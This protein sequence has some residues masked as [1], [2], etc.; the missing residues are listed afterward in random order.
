M[1]KAQYQLYCCGSRGS[2]PVEGKRFNEFG[3]FTS[4][5]VLKKEDYARIIDC[6]TGLYEANSIV[7]NCTKIDVVLTHIHY[8]HLMGMLDW[9]SIPGKAELTFYGN[10]D[11]WFGDKTF[12]E[13]FRNPFWPVQPKYELRQSPAAGELLQLRKDLS[14][15]FYSAPHPDGAKMLVIRHDDATEHRMAVMFDC[16][17]S[18]A[19]PYD[20]LNKSDYII[21]DGMYDDMEYPSHRGY[22]HSTWQEGCRL[23][24]RVNCSRLI[25]TH[26]FPAR[27]DDQLRRME[28]LARDMYPETDFARSGQNWE[29][30]YDAENEGSQ[31]KTNKEKKSFRE[32]VNEKLTELVLN[33]EQRARLLSIGCYMILGVVSVFMT[34][35]NVAT[36]KHLLMVSTLAFAIA[37]LLDVLFVT[38]FDLNY[39]SVQTVFQIEAL[40]LFAFFI[41]SGT[42][43]GFSAIWS[44]LLP[45]GGML[46]FGKRRTTILSISMLCI[47]VFFFYTVPGRNLLQYQYTESFMLRFPMAFVAF[48]LTAYFLETIRERTVNEL[49]RLK[50]NQADII[51]VQT[52]ELRE[53]NFDMIR[54][55]SKLELTNRLMRENISDEKMNE[56]MKE[57]EDRD[58]QVNTLDY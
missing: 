36:G 14:V 42:P 55:N 47:L 25:I 3:G 1:S 27:T 51:A 38:V 13:F 7:L 17:R 56:I 12:E 37:C 50:D 29:F 39:K 23:A 44:L 43:E 26:H 19:L 35:V 40:F 16:E 34:A 18:D 21:Y 22:G 9:V 31:A 58:A 46:I 2:R 33:D 32:R 45:V 49:R 4:C 30:P 11:E 52:S 24:E 57:I 54:I 6:G 28:Q 20:I 10:F 5:Y 53:K 15:E 48:F 8:D 41:V